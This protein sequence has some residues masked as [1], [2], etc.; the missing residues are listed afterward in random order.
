MNSE[1]IKHYVSDMK[2]TKWKVNTKKTITWKEGTDCNINNTGISE[3]PPA[4]GFVIS[5][6]NHK[7]S[8]ISV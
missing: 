6:K 5:F 1:T 2:K 8:K 4:F 3:D 7:F